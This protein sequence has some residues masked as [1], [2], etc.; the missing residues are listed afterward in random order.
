VPIEEN[1]AVARQVLDDL[2]SQGR[3][4]LVDQIYAQA[5]EFRD[6]TAG[7]TITTHYAEYMH[8]IKQCRADARAIRGHRWSAHEVDLALY[9]LGK[10]PSI[11]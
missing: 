5:F 9:V 4:E 8:R 1:R 2:V 10:M 3:V 7:Q 11:G 6:P